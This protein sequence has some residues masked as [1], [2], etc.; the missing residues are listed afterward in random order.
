MNKRSIEDKSDKLFN[1]IF[2]L[3]IV[4]FIFILALWSGGAYAVYKVLQHFGIF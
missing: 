4:Q 1:I 3:G 2:V